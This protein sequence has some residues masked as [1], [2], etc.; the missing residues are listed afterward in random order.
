MVSKTTFLVHLLLGAIKLP[1]ALLS[2]SVSLLNDALDTLMDALSSV[3]VFWGIHSDREQFSGFFLLGFMI[4]TGGYAMWESISRFISGS[5]IEADPIAFIAVII[6]ATLSALLWFYQKYA[7]LA[8]G[9]LS[10]LAQSVDSKNHLLVAGGV[11]ISLI[12]ASLGL[13]VID[14]IVGIAIA[15]MILK[16]AF[17]LLIDMIKQQ[18]GEELDLSAYGF[19][20]FEKHRHRQMI[21]WLLYEIEAGN[22]LNRDQLYQEALLS[23]DFE[24]IPQLRAFGLNE[25]TNA[26]KAASVAAEHLF[27]DGFIIEKKSNL[28]LTD[29]G[30]KELHRAKK[31]LSTWRTQTTHEVTSIHRI[32]QVL[33]F[34]IVFFFLLFAIRHIPFINNTIMWRDASPLFNISG[35]V[36]TLREIPFLITAFVMFFIGSFRATNARRVIH[37]SRHLGPFNE[38]IS[39]GP[40]QKFRFPI[41]GGRILQW[42]GLGIA[43]GSHITIGI[44][45]IVSV[46]QALASLFEERKLHSKHSQKWTAYCN[47]VK[48]RF[49]FLWEWIAIIAVLAA[50]IYIG[51]LNNSEWHQF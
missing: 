36:V 46:L 22:V 32:L 16:G 49:L 30:S 9:S 19:Q 28:Q 15:L 24:K 47:Q 13:P 2:G 51:I 17:D 4:I 5:A 48:R 7:G 10:I 27:D 11:C 50:W 23:V 25:N 31:M 18:Q 39:S 6:S 33:R 38:V 3:I 29:K 35:F 8:A 41:Y 37:V 44:A 42:M 43:C 26:R 1:A 40:F 14:L 45:F 21:R 12:A 20:V 34:S